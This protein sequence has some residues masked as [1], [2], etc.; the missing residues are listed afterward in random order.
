MTQLCVAIFVSDPAEAKRDIALAAEAGA[1][2]VELR[3]DAMTDAAIV[4]KVVAE[5]I[6]PCVVTC[7]PTWEGGQSEIPDAQRMELLQAAGEDGARYADVEL[8]TI[9]R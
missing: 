3:V 5:S 8:E 6:V 4:R 7:R 1:D 9:R 2:L